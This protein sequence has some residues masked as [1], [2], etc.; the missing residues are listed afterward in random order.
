MKES[1]EGQITGLR[2]EAGSEIRSRIEWARDRARQIVAEEIRSA[3]DAG[4]RGGTRTGAGRAA[5]AR[6]D[7]VAIDIQQSNDRGARGAGESQALDS[8]PQPA[9][10][11]KGLPV[12]VNADGETIKFGG[13]KPSQGA[14]G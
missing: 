14:A 12:E 10:R 8:R 3:S 5:A 1:N 6:R 11:G 2:P 7:D 4:V 9:T 13:I